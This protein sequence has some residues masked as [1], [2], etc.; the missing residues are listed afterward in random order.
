M[1]RVVELVCG[2]SDLYPGA[3]TNE[4]QTVSIRKRP[5]FGCETLPGNFA[6]FALSFKGKVTSSIGVDAL[7]EGFKEALESH[8]SIH[9]VK[10]RTDHHNSNGAGDCASQS[11][12]VSF[13][14]LVHKNRQG[15][16]DIGILMLAASSLNDSVVTQVDIFENIKGTNLGVFNI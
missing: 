10:V 8:V 4:V 16:G 14:H 3:F 13:T 2:A 6:R 9:T 7:L 12:I 15:A 5:G 1:V 11:W